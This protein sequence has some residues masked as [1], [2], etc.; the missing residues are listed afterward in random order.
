MTSFHT[1]WNYREGKETVFVLLGVIIAVTV[2]FLLFEPEE[3]DPDICSSFCIQDKNGVLRH[4]E[5]FERHPEDLPE[6]IRG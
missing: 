1:W 6:G 2:G 3:K 4:K 5:W